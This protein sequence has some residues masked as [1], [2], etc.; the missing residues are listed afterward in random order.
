MTEENET[1]NDYYLRR[2]SELDSQNQGETTWC[3]DCNDSG[4]IGAVL[5]SVISVTFTSMGRWETEAAL[6]IDR[7]A[8]AQRIQE[9]T[10]PN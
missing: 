1:L 4:E 9:A 7:Q 8:C 3:R 5:Q 10:S 2:A 6:C